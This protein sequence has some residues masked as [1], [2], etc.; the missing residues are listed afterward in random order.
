MRLGE[1]K[2]VMSLQAAPTTHG[3][4]PELAEQAA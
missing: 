4:E 1:T 3:S 2:K